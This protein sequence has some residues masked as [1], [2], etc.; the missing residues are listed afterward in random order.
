M[1]QDFQLPRDL[2]SMK[3]EA[4]GANTR[5][6]PCWGG[7]ACPHLHLPSQALTHSGDGGPHR[8]HTRPTQDTY[9]H[10]FRKR[11]TLTGI[12]DSEP[13]VQPQ[14]Q[15]GIDV[16]GLGPQE[17]PRPEKG[18]ETNFVETVPRGGGGRT[19]GQAGQRGILSRHG[20]A[21]TRPGSVAP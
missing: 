3:S 19:A 16:Q 17:E 9:V 5:D 2:V 12:P 11:H 4:L 18:A 15:D 10:N 1:G 20:W 7:A 21:R 6:E 14:T 8:A 13:C